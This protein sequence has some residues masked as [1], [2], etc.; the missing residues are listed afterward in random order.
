MNSA[1]PFALIIGIEHFA[2]KKLAE[3][4]SDKDINVIGVGEYVAGLSDIKNFEWL[5]DLSE[6]NG[7]F[8]Y[9]FD[10]KGDKNLW[11]T[12]QFKGEKITLICVND[13]EKA[14]QIKK[15]L[16]DLD[17][18]WRFIE[19]SGVYGPGMDENG[20]LA[21]AIKL[22]VVNKNLILPDLKKEFRILAIED[23]VEA[24][25]R[26]SF[27]SGTDG[28]KFLVLGNKTNSQEIAKVLIE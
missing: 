4:L 6:V 23:L 16:K 18:N 9:V 17:L 27:L 28:E 12:D 13:K 24:I 21:E 2:A 19:A 26:A 3:E 11:K 15:D 7:K 5:M 8:N 20:F 14:V 25:L 22:A 10:F 1:L